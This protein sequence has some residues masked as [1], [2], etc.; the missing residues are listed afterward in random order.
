MRPL[1]RHPTGVPGNQV[2]VS[3][4][5][6]CVL[7]LWWGAALGQ[8]RDFTFIHCSDTH[9]PVPGSEKL[10]PALKGIKEIRLTPYNVTAGPPSFIIVT[11]DLTEFG[12]GS[13]EHHLALWAG[14]AVPIHQVLG[15][16]DNTW[17]CCRPRLRKRRGQAYYSFDQ[18]GCHFAGLD[19]ATPQD[20]R[21]SI[22]EEQLFWL[23]KDLEAA[24][25][26]KPVF[27]FFHHPLGAKE[28]ASRYD[29]DRLAD[30][31]RPFNVALILMGH[32]HAARHQR[33]SGLDQVMGGSLYM[34]NPGWSVVS[35]LNGILRVA[36]QPA[37]QDEAIL[38]LLE[39]PLP[40]SPS[41]PLI[42]LTKPSHR[43][44]LSGPTLVVEAR[45]A[46]HP[47]PIAKAE[48]TLD[49]ASNGLLAESAGVYR[50]EISTKGWL[51]GAHSLRV[52]FTD[53]PGA[54]FHRSLVFYLETGRPSTR[55]RASLG[56]SSQCT[57][58][59]ANGVVYVG[60]NDG[61]LYAFN[62]SDGHERWR[63][64]TGGEI[65]AQPLP[66]GDTLFVA[67]GDG[68]LYALT[69]ETTSPKV[70]WV[71]L[72]EAALYSSPVFSD[73]LVL[74]GSNDGKLYAVDA[75][76]GQARWICQEAQYTIE[77][78]PFVADGAVYFGA[79][80][81]Y[82]YAVNVSDGS[83]RWKALSA[84]SDTNI[85]PRYYSP[86]DSGPVA[87]QG[88]VAVADRAYKLTLLDAAQA[89][90]LH[91]SEKC[92]AIALA[93]GGKALYR[94]QTDGK[95]VKSDWDGRI[96][97][98]ADVKTGMIPAAP[99]EADGVL[100]VTSNTGL[101]SAISADNGRVL[102]QYQATPQLYVMSGVALADGV[103]YVSGM[104]GTLTAIAGALE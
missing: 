93:A 9:V 7:L 47:A 21:P 16:H 71:F 69:D 91:V 49:E 96:L 18:F 52:N 62:A 78:K 85:A 13:W 43:A 11:G 50:S 23:R 28:F 25:A 61:A 29:S 59:V 95:L 68:Q 38:G 102:W 20:P 4:G 32:G 101:V 44:T 63:F 36:Y 75:D 72:A 54:T 79:W 58:T 77:S 10:I 15:N 41:Y 17:D 87:A 60:A 8:V 84:G 46:G 19:T 64:Q 104:D 88:R 73:G 2:S 35:V 82:V 76:T 98:S 45:I 48:W 56:G 53:A 22:G 37:G 86:A 5:S 6:L 97:W 12:G 70:K 40:K 55:W 99:T 83:L 51:P 81:R 80:D 74:F 92:A 1:R 24:G 27:L 103:A 90:R 31:V 65:L 100:Y 26:E 30:L 39:K 3:T 33:Y 34:P 57:P 67:S 94:R 66:H 42:S 89:T 14:L